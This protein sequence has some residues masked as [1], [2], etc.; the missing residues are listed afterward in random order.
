VL[1]LLAVLAAFLIAQAKK[2]TLNMPMSKLYIKMTLPD[3]FAESPPEA[4]LTLPPLKGKKTL[5]E[6]INMNVSIAEPYRAAFEG[7]NWFAD[8]TVFCA[9]SKDLLEIKVPANPGYTVKVDKQAGKNTAAFNKNGGAEIRIGSGGPGFDNYGE[10][11]IVF[12]NAGP[13]YPSNEYFDAADGFDIGGADKKT[14]GSFA[15]DDFW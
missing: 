4:A 1:L 12:G 10:Y 13:S 8:G 14:G 5:R 11:I 9:T 3:V 7:I 15:D 2:P 6:L